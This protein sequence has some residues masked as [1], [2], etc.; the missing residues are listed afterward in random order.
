MRL[1]G[2]RL[3]IL[4]GTLLSF[5]TINLI[6]KLL[7]STRLLGLKVFILLLFF[8]TFVLEEIFKHPSPF[9]LLL[10]GRWWL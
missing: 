7:A 5:L 9:Q 3:R 2:N 4:F 10:I 8:R 1:S 6:M